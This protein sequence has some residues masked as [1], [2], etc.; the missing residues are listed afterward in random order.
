[1]TA[2]LIKI[3]QRRTTWR[4]IR[5]PGAR[6]ANCGP[7]HGAAVDPQ[8]GPTA[9]PTWILPCRPDKHRPP[10]DQPYL[11]DPATAARHATSPTLQPRQSPPAMRTS[12][13][14]RPGNRRPPVMPPFLHTDP[15]AAARRRRSLVKQTVVPRS[16][17]CRPP[18][19]PKGI[20]GHPEGPAVGR[21]RRG[22]G[23]NRKSPQPYPAGLRVAGSAAGKPASDRTQPEEPAIGRGR[24]GEGCNRKARSR[25]RHGPA[26]SLAEFFRGLCTICKP[27]YTF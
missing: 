25:I 8:A 21:G 23:R 16:R 12:P 18:P 7:S 27:K 10:C 24:G 26:E 17:P 19:Q 15:T 13:P 6:H 20:E 1:M 9:R 2:K 3:C 5:R 22:E 11:A 4:K 14:C